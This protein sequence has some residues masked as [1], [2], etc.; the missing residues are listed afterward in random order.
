M[1]RGTVR[2]EMP[3]KSSAQ[4]QDNQPT[5]ES[6]LAGYASIKAEPKKP[7]KIVDTKQTILKDGVKRIS[8]W[9]GPFTIRGRNSTSP[10]SAYQSMDKYGTAWQYIAEDI[11]RDITVLK[12]NVSVVYA[13]GSPADVSNGI[14]QHHSYLTAAT[15]QLPK[16]STCGV[17][18]KMIAEY[19]SPGSLFVG[20]AEDK[21]G[22][23]FT[24]PTGDL[25]SGYY[26]G[27]E[28]K[29]ILNGDVVNYTPNDKVVYSVNEI[30]YIPG[31][32]A[33]LMAASMYIMVPGQCAGDQVA[34]SSKGK[35]ER[36]TVSGPPQTVTKDA[37]ILNFRGHLHDGGDTMAVKI[38]DKT[39]CTSEAKY[40]FAAAFSGTGGMKKRVVADPGPHGDATSQTILEMSQCFNIPLKKGDTYAL[41][42]VYDTKKHPT[43]KMHDGGEGEM[44]ALGVAFIALKE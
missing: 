15:K 12:S 4:P 37:T 5:S 13:D 28:D 16:W 30:E 36:F 11:P 27:K 6:Q 33:D 7:F 24:T 38:N 32:P 35:G 9:Y 25:N 42:A 2:A 3:G 34:I 29:L 14:Y 17:A 41:E 40:G 10:P 26:I 44:M 19:Y 18:P 8:I 1:F 20:G 22:G 31:K 39:V 23:Y 43:R 21:F